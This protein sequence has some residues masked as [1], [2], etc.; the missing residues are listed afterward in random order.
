MDFSFPLQVRVVVP[1]SLVK[2]LFQLGRGLPKAR[3]FLIPELEP[4]NS[5]GG[6]WRNERGRRL[7]RRPLPLAVQLPCLHGSYLEV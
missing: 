5:R 6:F 1:C 7:M 2:S 3:S 4:F